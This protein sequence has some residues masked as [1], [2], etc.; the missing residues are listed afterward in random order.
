MVYDVM[1]IDFKV[2]LNIQYCNQ[3]MKWSQSSEDISGRLMKI[4]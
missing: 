3:R 4:L 2:D 1:N